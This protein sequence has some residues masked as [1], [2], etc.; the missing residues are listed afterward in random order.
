MTIQILSLWTVLVSVCLGSDDEII[1]MVE[2]DKK[3]YERVSVDQL[4][5]E[6]GEK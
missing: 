2:S 5:V 6:G 1:K 3:F 4:P